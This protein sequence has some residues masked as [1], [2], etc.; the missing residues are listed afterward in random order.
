MRRRLLDLLAALA[1]RRSGAVLLVSFVLAAVAGALAA[2]RL[3]LD[4]NQDHLVSTELPFQRTYQDYVATF[5][6][7]EYLYL[8]IDGRGRDAAADA[9]AEAVTARLRAQPAL[10]SGVHCG[11]GAELGDGLL[12]LASEQDLAQLSQLLEGFPPL[13]RART[14]AGLV[15]ALADQIRAQPA[16]AAALSSD[17][18]A[19]GLGVLEALADQTEA[20]APARERA[21]LDRFLPEVDPAQQL[22]PPGSLRIVSAIPTKDYAELD[23]IAGSLDAARAALRAALRE[24]PGVEGGVTGRPAIASDEVRRTSRDTTYSALLALGGVSLLFGLFFRGVLRPLLAVLALLV[25][26][27]WTAGFATLALGRLNLLS[28]V[29]LIVLIGLGVDYAVHL[30]AHYQAA[31]AGRAGTPDAG[32]PDAGTPDA[33]TPDAGTPD[34]GTPDAGTPDAG[35]PDAG[36]PDAGTPDA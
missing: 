34:A 36:T 2:T 24:H 13:A 7:S 28:S 10:F 31:L 23:P 4:S 9:V 18:L 6:D 27:A 8:V 14:T 1:L 3:A 33:G 30:L 19:Q 12:L 21:L 35:T 15:Q 32:T 25:G 26:I 22:T 16:T 17:A 5:G 11:V 29:F 20:P